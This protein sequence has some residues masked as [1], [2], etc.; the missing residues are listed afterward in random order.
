[1]NEIC[2]VETDT[3]LKELVDLAVRRLQPR[4]IILF[5]SRARGDH[6]RRSDYDVAIEAPAVSE[7]EWT[8]FVLDIQDNLDTL[9]GIDIVRLETVNPALQRRIEREG[10]VLWNGR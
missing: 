4:R 9:H 10:K 5:G 1:M 6:D 7:A 2:A 8:R 3:F